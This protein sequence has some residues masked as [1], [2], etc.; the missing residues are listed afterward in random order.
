MSDFQKYLDE[1]LANV[2][3]EDEKIVEIQEYDILS[4]VRELLLR[5]RN[6]LE[7]SQKE[8]SE[9]TGISQANISK[10]ESGRSVPSL[11]V[12]KRLADGFGKRLVIDFVDEEEG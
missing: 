7:I 9:K 2:K 6:E 8:L 12:L 1:F 11:P 4:E 10:I 5:T 3:F